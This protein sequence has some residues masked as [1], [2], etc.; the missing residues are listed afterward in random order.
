MNQKHKMALIGVVI[1]IAGVRVGDTGADQVVIE[2]AKSFYAKVSGTEK[3]L[4]IF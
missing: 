1:F 2:A 3:M 4:G